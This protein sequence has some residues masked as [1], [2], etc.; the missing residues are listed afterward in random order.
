[1]TWSKLLLKGG[2]ALILF[3]LLVCAGGVTNS[4]NDTITEAAQ[5]EFTNVGGQAALVGTMAVLV[6]AIL[7]V[8]GK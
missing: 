6:G 5:V 4:I 1:M 7:R 3:G 8:W 2:L